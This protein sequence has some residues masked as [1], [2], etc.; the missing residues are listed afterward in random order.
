VRRRRRRRRGMCL[1]RERVRGWSS[2][3]VSLTCIRRNISVTK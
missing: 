1:E 3:V 2:N